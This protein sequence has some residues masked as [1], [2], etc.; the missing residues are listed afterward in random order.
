MA[1]MGLEYTISVDDPDT[2]LEVVCAESNL[3]FGLFDFYMPVA[4]KPDF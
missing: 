1:G 4:A 3:N 2:Y